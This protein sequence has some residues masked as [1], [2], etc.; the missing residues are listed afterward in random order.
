MPLLPRNIPTA[1][2]ALDGATWADVVSRSFLLSCDCAHGLHPNYMSGALSRFVEDS[3][4]RESQ[5]GV[6]DGTGSWRVSSWVASESRAHRS[7]FFFCRVSGKHQAQHQPLLG[8]GIVIKS[9]SNQRYATTPLLAQM[10]RR[11]GELNQVPLQDDACWTMG[12]MRST[13]GQVEVIFWSGLSETLLMLGPSS[14][15]P[16][17][18]I[19]RHIR[20]LHGFRTAAN[21]N[22]KAT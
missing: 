3:R 16:E 21:S 10:I 5:G 4:N 20:N 6:N 17:D 19:R 9:N 13:C 2:E 8:K 7:P 11:V 14:L 18:H 22:H 12:T 1:W 15:D